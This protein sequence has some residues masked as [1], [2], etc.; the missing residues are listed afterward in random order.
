[1]ILEPRTIR[2]LL[3]EDPTVEKGE[4]SERDLFAEGEGVEDKSG[5]N[6]DEIIFSAKELTRE[7]GIVDEGSEI[8]LAFSIIKPKKII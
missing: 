7:E 8:C 1:M 5:K 3:D 6:K 2:E 4:K